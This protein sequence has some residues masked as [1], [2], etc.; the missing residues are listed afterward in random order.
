MTYN[1]E[2]WKQAQKERK[3]QIK[4][5]LDD[6]I[7]TLVVSPD[8]MDKYLGALKG[9]YNYSLYN[10]IIATYD[11]YIQKFEEENVAEP[12]IFQTFKRWKKAGR[13]VRKGEKACY[14]IRPTHYKVKETDE[15]GNEIESLRLGGFKPFAVFALSQTDGEPLQEQKLI[16]GESQ[17]TFE[18]IVEIYKDEFKILYETTQLRR[19]ATNGE[20]IKIS[21][22]SNE[23]YKI[24]TIIHEVAHNRLGHLK[25][26]KD[27]PT[28]ELEAESVAYMVTTMLGLQNEKSRLYICNWNGNDAREAVRKRA[29]TLIKT[30]EAIHKEIVGDE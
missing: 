6:F 28:A 2:A 7:P 30:A 26:Q 17:V 24:S 3:A 20:Y 15:D 21:T 23:N 27:T 18:N 4:Q 8:E 1:K 19:G 22:E 25:D 13:Y 29:N 9:M 16:K 10:Q 11:Y 14:M 12:E 5:V